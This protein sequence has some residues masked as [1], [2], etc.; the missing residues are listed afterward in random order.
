VRKT[1]AEE[2]QLLLLQLGF[3]LVAMKRC[4]FAKPEDEFWNAS[5]RSFKEYQ[6]WEQILTQHANE[7]HH[8]LQLMSKS[9]A[10]HTT[11]PPAELFVVESAS[12]VADANMAIDKPGLVSPQE[13]E[14][15]QDQPRA[16]LTSKATRKSLRKDTDLAPNEPVAKRSKVSK[17]AMVRTAKD[18][19]DN[20]RPRNTDRVPSSSIGTRYVVFSMSERLSQQYQVKGQGCCCSEHPPDSEA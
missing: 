11:A 13:L 18:A 19:E 3:A 2:K 16:S 7:I 6:E 1:T 9:E 5:A 17:K 4:A 10:N 20:S 12:V 15:Q 14:E 8:A